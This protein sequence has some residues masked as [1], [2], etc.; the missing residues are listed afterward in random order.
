[1]KKDGWLFIGL[2]FGSSGMKNW[3]Y[4]N[5]IPTHMSR[6]YNK[7]YEFFGPKAF[8]KHNSYW[9]DFGTIKQTIE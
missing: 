8:K 2:L 3:M 7:N 9:D 1:V 4:R 6:M 5:N